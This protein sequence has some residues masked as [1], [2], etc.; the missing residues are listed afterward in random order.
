MYTFFKAIL[1][2]IDIPRYLCDLKTVLN[3]GNY[4]H[5]TILLGLRSVEEESYWQN[6]DKTKKSMVPIPF[7][8]RP[9]E[10][11]ALHSLCG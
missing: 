7:K 5:S 3:Y 11:W 1:A 9:I 8:R 6:V 4:D 10:V 2:E